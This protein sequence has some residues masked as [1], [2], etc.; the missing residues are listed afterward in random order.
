M[1]RVWRRDYSVSGGYGSPR[2]GCQRHSKNG[3]SAC[4]NR[5]TIRAKVADAVLLEGLQA[6]LL[7]PST[8]DYIAGQLTRA[9]NEV[10]DQRP[11][12]R[13]ELQRT[14]ET[15]EQKLRNLVAAVEN[16]AG[17]PTVFQAI[18]DREVEIRVLDGQLATDD[19]PIAERLA[20][21]PTWV[22]QQLEDA[23]G[24]LREGPERAKTE[25]QR[26]GIRFTV[27]PVHDEGPRPFLRGGCR[28]LRA[29]RVQSARRVYYCGPIGPAMA[30]VKIARVPLLRSSI[31]ARR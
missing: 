25:F 13:A 7:R 4:G 28:Q 16:G 29:P 12:R 1:R 9:L 21:I 20:V 2:Y 15:A 5:L 6:E 11:Q 30:T 27:H 14:R 17:A 31:V 19:E 18:K 26:L 23:A 10:V 22:R 8:V 3:A 24:L